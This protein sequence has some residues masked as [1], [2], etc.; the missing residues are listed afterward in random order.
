MV[1]T[2][3]TYVS[4]AK[5]VKEQAPDLFEQVRRGELR[6]TQARQRLKNR[7]KKAELEA[8]KPGTVVG[9]SVSLELRASWSNRHFAELKHE[10]QSRTQF[11]ERQAEIERLDALCVRLHQESQDAARQASE[12]RRQLDTDI[13]RAVEEEHGPSSCIGWTEVCLSKKSVKLIEG[14]EDPE[15]RREE[16]L[17]LSRRCLLCEAHLRANDPD[18]YCSWCDEHRG[19][20]HC[21]GCG[22]P[23]A[24][25]D[26]TGEEGCCMTCAPPS[27][28]ML[29][30]LE[31][32]ETA[33][34]SSP[35]E[36]T[37]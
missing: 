15:E 26:I 14:I 11:A 31:V 34:P 16:L 32:L 28:E 3:K 37:D 24:A 25:E 7:E 2:N 12:L 30:F 4:V 35:A 6:V 22:C 18:P 5:K 13:R 17:W 10:V 21:W 8:H 19:K 23:L 9:N 20:T 29:R 27:E 1:G 36:R 33:A